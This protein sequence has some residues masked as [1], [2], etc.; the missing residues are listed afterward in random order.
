MNEPKAQIFVKEFLRNKILGAPLNVDRIQAAGE[1]IQLQAI[2]GVLD[3]T[4]ESPLLAH[5]IDDIAPDLEIQN[6]S[7]ENLWDELVRSSAIYL[8]ESA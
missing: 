2:P 4:A 1:L 7:V 8:R 3:L 5:M 6:G